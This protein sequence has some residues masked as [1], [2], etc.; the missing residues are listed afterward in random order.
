MSLDANKREQCP[1]D[2]P[3]IGPCV[4]Y[5][6]CV[7]PASSRSCRRC[8]RLG[9]RQQMLDRAKW[10]ASVID[11]AWAVRDANKEGKP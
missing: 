9:S 1:C 2:F 3:E 5:C 4:K 7:T 8:N 11:A 10:L 6:P